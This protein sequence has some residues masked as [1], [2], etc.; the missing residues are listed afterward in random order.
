MIDFGWSRRGA[1]VPRWRIFLTLASIAVAMGACGHGI[2]SSSSSSSSVTTARS[3]YV[4]NFA[5]AKV[6]EL[7]N[8]A[9]VLSNP[10]TLSG[11]KVNGPVGLT[12]TPPASTLP[13]ALYVANSADNKIHEFTINSI[14]DL[15]AL[16]TIAAGT[17][18]Q[19][20]VTDPTGSFAYAINSGGSISQY[21]IDTTTRE[22]SANSPSFITAGL[23]APV[24]AVSSGSYLYVTDPSN[25]AGLA[26][27]F[28]LT[29][30]LLSFASSVATGGTNPGPIATLS[31]SGFTW[32]F[33]ADATTGVV[34]VF[35]A[36]GSALSLFGTIS[37]GAAA[38]GLAVGTNTSG[39]TFLYVSNP[40]LNQVVTFSFNTTT[41]VLA[42][43]AVTT[44]FKSPTGL[45]VD[46]PELE[47][48]LFVA[49]NTNGTVSTLTI[50]ATTGELSLINSY[51]TESPANSSSA[52]E[53]IAVI[54]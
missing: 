2:F 31:A 7:T 40:S 19:Q 18:P 27:T 30:G 3:V 47:T 6:S 29:N 51:A 12:L 26:L 54:P 21:L 4:T 53:N 5:D 23:T 17:A 11:G 42:A 33:V 13:I 9:G 22:L 16:A 38:A 1:A 35:Q 15:T 52:P 45:A 8:N 14:G 32:V 44:G 46:N 49:N 20:I 37:T 41:G 50:N 43:F 24:N 48:T 10:A 36:Q 28:L 25:G 39:L 34:T